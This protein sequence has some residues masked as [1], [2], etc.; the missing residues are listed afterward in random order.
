MARCADVQQKS[1]SRRLPGKHGHSLP[2]RDVHRNAMD[3]A[4]PSSQGWKSTFGKGVFTKKIHGQRFAL[5]PR[6]EISSI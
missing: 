3:N 2:L 4:L 1:R 6:M 5:Q